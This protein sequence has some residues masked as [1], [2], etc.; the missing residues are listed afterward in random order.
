MK[1]LALLFLLIACQTLAFATEG[2]ALRIVSVAEKVLRA[3]QSGD[4]SP[5]I[6]GIR[7]EAASWYGRCQQNVRELV[8]LSIFG[9]EGDWPESGCCA[10]QT[11][12]NLKKASGTVV[13]ER[14]TDLKK[15]I[16]GD[17]V[18]MNCSGVFCN[19]CGHW[20]GHAMVCVAIKNGSQIF[21]QN[22][23]GLC[24]KPLLDWQKK[25]FVAAYRFKPKPTKS[26][27]EQFLVPWSQRL[28]YSDILMSFEDEP[29]RLS[30]K[31]KEN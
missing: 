12:K 6:G 27:E 7:F 2:P 24:K 18:Y 10:T 15:V 17:L 20:A 22:L 5:K 29:F 9:K 26:I 16:P 3:Y 19:D 31:F 8:E 14:I 28:K 21:W 23:S 11:E 30:I 4:T 25:S 1:K 13:Y